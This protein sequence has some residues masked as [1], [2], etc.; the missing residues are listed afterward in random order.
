[1][2]DAPDPRARRRGRWAVALLLLGLVVALVPG[3]VA[4]DE[5]LGAEI[6]GDWD[7]SIRGV[8]NGT[9]TFVGPGTN[10]AGFGGRPTH[11]VLTTDAFRTPLADSLVDSVRTDLSWAGSLASLIVAPLLFLWWRRSAIRFGRIVGAACCVATSTV[12][13]VTL[14]THP[15]YE[16]ATLGRVWLTVPLGGALMA[17]A[18]V[19]APAPRVRHE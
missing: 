15:M 1:M 2:S 17:A 8:A 13:C 19:V 16:F 18:F 3:L 11:T 12:V 10:H 6:N 5:F 14:L 7:V 4:G 9:F